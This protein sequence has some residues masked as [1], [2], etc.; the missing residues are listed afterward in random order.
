MALPVYL[1]TPPPGLGYGG[2]WY[3]YSPYGN[4]TLP[5]E[6]I[7]VDNGYGGA[8]YGHNSYGSIDNTPPR[9]SGA[10]SLDGFRV[11][12]FFSEEMK[13]NAALTNPSNYTLTPVIGAPSD[14]L[15]VVPGTPGDRGGYTSV[16]ITH[17]G[18]TLGGRYVV[19]VI[20][21]KDLAGNSINALPSPANQAT[22][23]TY[24]DIGSYTI[25]APTGNS[26][27]VQ[28]LTSLGGP[29][30]MLSE[31][32]FSPG[33][34]DASNYDITTTYPIN[35]GI[36]SLQQVPGDKSQVTA[37]VTSMT[38]APYTVEISPATA[39]NYKGN[40]LPSAAS[41]FLGVSVGTG[42]S[43]ASSATKLLL[44]KNAGVFYGWAF[45]DTSGKVLPSSSYRLDFSFDA[46]VASYTPPLIN[47]LLG[48][49]S[50]SDGAVQID[51]LI[52][53]LAGTD[54]LE[55]S[56]GIFYA[57][58]PVDWSTGPKVIT[59]LRNQKADHFSL[60]VDGV[61][62][63]SA[64]TAGFT[65]VPTINPGTRFLLSTTYAVTDF[66]ISV[67]KVT[68]SQTIFTTAWNFLHSIAGAFTGSSL[69]AN[70][71]ILTKRGP[72]VKDWGD[73]TP[74]TKEDVTVRVNGTP[75]TVASVNPYTG[76]I[77]PAIPIPRALVG[78]N[79]IEVDYTWFPSPALPMVGLNTTGLVLNKWNLP[80]GHTYPPV[81]PLP[82]GS[83][84]AMDVQRFP[85]GIVLPPLVRP[86]PIQIG[87][88]Y[89][90]FERAYSALL[91]SPTTLLL[92]Q[93]PHR[94]SVPGLESSC[95]TVEARFDG[96]TTP[97]LAATPW[98]LD[99]ADS[100]A[101]VGDGTYRVVDASA[102]TYA[103]GTA[104]VYFREEDLACEGTVRL[105]A[106]LRVDSY[107]A[108]GVFTG[109]GFGF[110]DNFRLYM[111]G[112]LA[113]NGLRHVGLLRDASAPDQITSWEPGPSAQ[114]TITA[115]NTMTMPAN[116][117]PSFVTV[118]SKFQILNGPQAGIYTVAGCGLDIYLGVA[119]ITLDPEALFPA[120]P[121]LEGNNTATVL[122]D[123]AWDVAPTT[124]QLIATT[125]LMDRTL[126]LFIGGSLAS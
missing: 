55:V 63:L 34:E 7:P 122:F 105:G 24:G 76:T 98:L 108:D 65:G 11:E 70:D 74:A 41:S 110:H 94:V 17:E 106:R 56:S 9:V 81:S 83:L 87:H 62:L 66:R 92:N 118:G 89:M 1:P 97:Q 115:Y 95:P 111:A 102:G 120:N 37:A 104:A 35:I 59:L 67:V 60:L 69:L 25:T 86:Q 90:G 123:M 4:G 46:S 27:L 50:F 125:D 73:P 72:L 126:R 112:L 100:G 78:V 77:F 20:N 57:Q 33:V 96:T 52:S 14:V 21:V 43:T 40:Q 19:T 42:T 48:F 28:Y 22:F 15:S 54:I 26:L 38:S 3:G 88:R 53:R 47:A 36:D 13:A 84:G 124:F 51:V 12:V 109:V 58:I 99:G 119:S 39:Y 8:A 64:L 107:T 91:N 61:P 6:P 101:V 2:A 80:R 5:R 103:T 114:V 82:A 18:T 71:R 79:L 121:A 23:L 30:K 10:I 29:Q 32:Q 49:V 116:V 45:E 44:S 68:S 113:V 31:A 117:L 16:I 85:M 93:N 75:V